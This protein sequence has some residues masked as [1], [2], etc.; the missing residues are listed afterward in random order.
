MSVCIVCGTPC[1]RN[2]CP[3]PVPEI[4]ARAKAL[5]EETQGADRQAVYEK[6]LPAL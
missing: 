3:Y 1:W 6:Y 2:F 4:K 5:L